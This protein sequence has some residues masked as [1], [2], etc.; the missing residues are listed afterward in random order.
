M[1]VKLARLFQIIELFGGIVGDGHFPRFNGGSLNLSQKCAGLEGV[2]G[3]G[4]F[5]TKTVNVPDEAIAISNGL[6]GSMP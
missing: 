2:V 6:I 3:M 5:G 1:R 4:Q